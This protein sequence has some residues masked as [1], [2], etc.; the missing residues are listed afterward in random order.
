MTEYEI[1]KI[2]KDSRQSLDNHKVILNNIYKR[3]YGG[4]KPLN[5]LDNRISLEERSISSLKTKIRKMKRKLFWMKVNKYF[6]L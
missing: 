2:I 3:F 4:I 1:K 6:Y 5:V